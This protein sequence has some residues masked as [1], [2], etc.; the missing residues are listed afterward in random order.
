MSVEQ[1]HL[2]FQLLVA[3]PVPSLM[4]LIVLGVAM[5]RVVGWG[6]ARQVTNLQ[7]QNRTHEARRQLA[8]EQAKIAGGKVE[9]A[10]HQ[11]AK[12]EAQVRAADGDWL[13]IVEGVKSVRVYVHEAGQANNAVKASL[14]SSY[15]VRHPIQ[16]R[17][18]VVE[19]VLVPED[20]KKKD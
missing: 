10:E 1:W 7:E 19:P 5:W 6:F 8:E 18:Q 3:A 17:G 16:Y 9:S 20:E 4:V 11:I 13:K 14:S 2:F 15:P 12:L